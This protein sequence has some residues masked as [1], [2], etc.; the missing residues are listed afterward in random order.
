MIVVVRDGAIAL[1]TYDT[2]T[3]TEGL[4]PA[5]ADIEDIRTAL[6]EALEFIRS[7]PL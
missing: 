5:K 2:D 4:S 3:K 1:Y 7:D 6:R